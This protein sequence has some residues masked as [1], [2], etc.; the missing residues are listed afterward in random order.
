MMQEVLS[1]RFKRLTVDSVSSTDKLDKAAKLAVNKKDASFSAIPDLIVVDGGKG[2]LSSAR[3]VL[4]QM[5]LT[6]PIVGMTKREEELV[7]AQE[8]VAIEVQQDEGELVPADPEV[9]QIFGLAEGEQTPSPKKS[10]AKRSG[11]H[12]AIA[13]TQFERQTTTQTEEHFTTIRLARGTD[14]LFFLQRL[15]DE[16]HRFAITYHRK[17]RAKAF[18]PE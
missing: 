12:G 5:G 2:Q 13:R 9:A 15:R 7:V 17:L 6:I 10:K 1:R 14:A 8:G 18:L 3:Q 16:A 11:A 4:L